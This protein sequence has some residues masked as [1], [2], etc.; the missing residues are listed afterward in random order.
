MRCNKFLYFYS[1]GQIF[2]CCVE[3]PR[4]PVSE[5]YATRH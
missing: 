4:G 5:N 2:V 3:I 1:H